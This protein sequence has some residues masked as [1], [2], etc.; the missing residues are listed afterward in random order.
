MITIIAKILK[1]LNSETDPAQTGLAFFAFSYPVIL[2]SDKVMKV[3]RC[4]HLS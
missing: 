4:I 1:V 3:N 2:F